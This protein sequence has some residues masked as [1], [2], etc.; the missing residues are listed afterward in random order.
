[1]KSKEK[2]E[3]GRIAKEYVNGIPYCKIHY[4]VE[5]SKQK[6]ERKKNE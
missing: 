4:F 5:L 3:C 2:C 6:K 1:M